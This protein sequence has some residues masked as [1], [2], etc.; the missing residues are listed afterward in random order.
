[1]ATHDFLSSC[2]YSS[3]QFTASD[4]SFLSALSSPVRKK[5]NILKN[6]ELTLLLFRNPL[7]NYMMPGRRQN[8]LPVD[9]YCNDYPTQMNSTFIRQQRNE[10]NVI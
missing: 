3:P 4:F 2:R 6:K 8:Q 7:Q 10:N 1:V 9:L 5:K